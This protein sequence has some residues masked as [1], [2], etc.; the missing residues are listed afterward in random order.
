MKELEVGFNRVSDN[1]V[2]LRKEKGD[3]GAQLAARTAEK[4]AL[5]KEIEKLKNDA[6]TTE[7]ELKIKLVSIQLDSCGILQ[8]RKV[9][10]RLLL[11]CCSFVN[12]LL[13]N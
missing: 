9:N 6:N 8:H 2:Q 7:F 13:I 4:A 11:D 3:L 5:E 10:I 12:W 1:N